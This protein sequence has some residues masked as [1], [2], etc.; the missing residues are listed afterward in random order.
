L[1]NAT[2]APAISLPVGQSRDGLPIGAMLAAL[3]GQDVLL[4][5][6]A[7]QWEAAHGP[8]PTLFTA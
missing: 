5:R 4:L 7:A 2:G 3:H 6:V 8:V 1:A